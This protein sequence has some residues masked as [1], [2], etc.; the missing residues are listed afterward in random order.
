[1][2]PAAALLTILAQI[3]RDGPPVRV[4][5]AVISGTVVSAGSDA[6]PVRHARVTCTAAELA[7]GVTAITDTAGHFSCEQLPPGRYALVASRDGWLTSAYGASRPGGAAHPIPIAADQHFDVVLKMAR[8]AVITGT[9]MDAGGQPA[10][11]VAVMALRQVTRNGE[12]RL[13]PTGTG[14]TTDDRGVY[15]IYDLPPGNYL[16]GAAPPEAPSGVG[17][18]DLRETSDLDVQHARTANT[19]APAPPQRRVAFAPTYFPGTPVAGQAAPVSVRAGEEREGIDFAIE[20]VATARLAGA[21]TMPDGAPLPS[22]AQVTLAANDQTA[23]PGLPFDGVQAVRVPP[24]GSFSFTGIGPGVY[25]LLARAV[26]PP[27][28]GSAPTG[29]VLWAAAEIAVDGEPIT[30]MALTLQ[31]GLTISGR[32]RFVGES[33]RPPSDFT[34]VRVTAEPVQPPGGIALAP[35]SV[36]ADRDGRFVLTGVT[37]GR[38]RVTASL[39]GYRDWRLRSV[40]VNDSDV[41]DVP[42]QMEPTRYVTNAVVTFTDRPS[43]VGG[44]VETPDGASDYTVIVFPT[45]RSLWLPRA[46]RIQAAPVSSDR[47]YALPNLPPGQYVAV[48]QQDVEPGEWFDPAFLERLLP[49]GMPFAIGEGQQMRLDIR[50][51]GG[52]RP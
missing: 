18:S 51:G 23:F 17:A 3:P 14:G 38:Y 28:P 19:A 22:S 30:G 36:A 50:G 12:R 5:T 52:G 43:G 39:P 26:V 29:R 4:G 8:G 31:P 11:S 41:L 21:L 1:M 24:D 25:S 49:I 9:V 13:V 48:A 45:D 40:L 7:V 33:A 42:L 10:V 16:V 32:V 34:S 2:I 37:P 20:L 44:H 27:D 6:R 46:R 35:A 47:T 15:R